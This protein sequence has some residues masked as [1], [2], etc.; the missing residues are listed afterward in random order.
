MLDIGRLGKTLITGGTGFIG[1]ELVKT[2]VDQGAD[3]RVLD[4]NVRGKSSRLN[5]YLNRLEF[6]KGDVTNY[7]DVLAA[8][9]D[10]KTVFHLAFINGTDNFY[11]F[12]EKVLEV[13]VKGAI[14]TLDAAMELGV[15]N[16]IVTSSSEV[17][18]QP[19]TIPTPE[20]ERIII[21]DI[22][23]PRFSYSGGKII[24]ELLAI[25]YTAKN[26]INT[27]IFR[28]HNFFGPDMGMGHVIP[29]FILRMKELS[30]NFN[31]KEID[32]PIQGTGEETRSFCYIKDAIEALLIAT[33][34]GKK[35]EIYHGGTQQEISIKDLAKEISYL[36]GLKIRIT[37]GD[38]LP[39]GTQRRCP[40][41]SKLK[42]LGYKP[43]YSLREALKETISWYIDPNNNPD[44]KTNRGITR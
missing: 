35:G 21:P 9:K 22:L 34:K 36:L 31:I 39:G 33:V 42:D 5:G 13:G 1:A 8:T 17:Y 10:I 23:N 26:D 11:N 40:N 32:F 18:Q 20:S 7:K 27:I 38:L 6:I 14:T 4:N 3:I 29:Q 25:H 41:I 16:Y 2:L 30:K 24:T 43:K 12:P 28:P 19:T 44:L 37:E 15:K